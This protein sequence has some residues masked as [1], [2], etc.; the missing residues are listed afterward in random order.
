MGMW[1]S[2]LLQ[3][4]DMHTKESVEDLDPV[5]NAAVGLVLVGRWFGLEQPP[6]SKRRSTNLPSVRFTAFS[7]SALSAI[8]HVDGRSRGHPCVLPRSLPRTSFLWIRRFAHELPSSRDSSEGGQRSYPRI[9][10][11]E[12]SSNP[13]QLREHRG[14]LLAGFDALDCLAAPSHTIRNGKCV[15]WWA[16]S[17]SQV[18]CARITSLP[19][20]SGLLPRN[21]LLSSLNRARIFAS[22]CLLSCCTFGQANFCW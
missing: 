2:I 8:F 13:R 5:L 9:Q 15:A 14:P 7:P 17:D 1:A 16:D 21:R 3:C 22:T 4:K 20:P 11:G 10:L 19:G 18:S 12:G 6:P